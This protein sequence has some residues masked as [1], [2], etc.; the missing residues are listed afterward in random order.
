MKNLF[1]FLFLLLIPA[2]LQS[3][4]V[5][6][7]EPAPSQEKSLS[8]VTSFYPLAF[9]AEEIGGD[10][11][12]VVNLAGARDPHEFTPSPRDMETIY[13]ADIFVFSGAELEP[14]IDGVIPQLEKKS[15]RMIDMSTKVILA[16]SEEHEHEGEAESEVEE[17][18]S[19]GE[20][21]PHT[22]LDFENMKKMTSALSLELQQLD[23][24]DA[25]L[26]AENEKVLNQKFS[27]LDA[28]FQAGL[29]SCTQKEALISHDSVG[30][31]ARKYHLELHPIAGISTMDEPSAKLIA[32]L[33]EEASSGVT[34]ILT[35][36][37]S[38]KRFAETLARE[39]GLQMLPFNPLEQGTFDASK[40][41]FDV[42]RENLLS[43]Q[44]ALSCNP[45]QP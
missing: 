11:V 42:M 36:E 43:L 40:S 26:Y 18:H 37:N 8:V 39:T 45:V 23:A 25:N 14:W 38:V 34:T 44:E 31:L 5:T 29:Q 32:E 41:Y 2:M 15:V 19:H 33:K 22:W 10:A 17:E 3:C 7:D 4:S 16:K 12:S 28:E 1:S 27:E 21:D 35:E 6:K 20:F 9:L 30:Y 24:M 13:N